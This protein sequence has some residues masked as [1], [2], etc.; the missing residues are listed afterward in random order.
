MEAYHCSWDTKEQEG[1]KVNKVNGLEQIGKGL[2]HKTMISLLRLWTHNQPFFDFP[3]PSMTWFRHLGQCTPYFNILRSCDMCQDLSCVPSHYQR[4]AQGTQISH[5]VT[6]LLY[7]VSKGST[8]EWC[9]PC[10]PS[11]LKF[12][13]CYEL[14]PSLNPCFTILSSYF[15][16]FHCLL[17]TTNWL[18]SHF[19]LALFY[20]LTPCT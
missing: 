14:F 2:K 16:Q 20:Y 6:H 12:Y 3:Q 4:L 13:L 5:D 9:V 7:M 18:C 11:C 19:Y 10:M 8:L 1:H 17:S 15:G